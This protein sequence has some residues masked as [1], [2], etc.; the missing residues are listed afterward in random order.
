M[1]IFRLFGVKTRRYMDSRLSVSDRID[2]AIDE[3]ED[4][5]ADFKEQA[6]NFKTSNKQ[7]WS[8]CDKFN[9][10]CDQSYRE[11]QEL[12]NSNAAE[13]TV[14]AKLM[15]Y[16]SYKKSYDMLRAQYDS[17]NKKEDDLNMALSMLSARKEVL[18][19]QAQVA[20]L[21]DKSGGEMNIDLS[22][23]NDLENV[24]ENIT[25]RL[26]A[27]EEVNKLTAVT[28]TNNVQCSSKE[29]DDLYHKL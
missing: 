24:I 16:A 12:K 21:R 29:I 7:L 10:L 1:N 28:N 18:M 13:T 26:E 14:K 17:S 3:L 8:T 22:F 11:A 6:I 23:M 9:K 27:K 15:V 25:H 20:K 2:Y 5:I 19:S 4:K